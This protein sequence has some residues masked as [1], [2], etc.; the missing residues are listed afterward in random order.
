[1][2]K[3]LALSSGILLSIG[4]SFAE[5]IAWER[6]FSTNSSNVFSFNNPNSGT[7]PITGNAPDLNTAGAF[8]FDSGSSTATSP[9][10]Q[11]IAN[12]GPTAGN[13]NAGEFFEFTYS[14]DHFLQDGGGSLNFA[15][16]Y[17]DYTVEVFGGD[18][19]I[20][21]SGITFGSNTNNPSDGALD[22]DYSI[23]GNGTSSIFLNNLY[24]DGG[25]GAFYGNFS[26]SGEWTGFRIRQSHNPDDPDSHFLDGRAIS[27]ITG[28]SVVAPVPES[29][30]ALLSLLA[31][32]LLIRRK[33]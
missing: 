32:A 24:A 5:E 16:Q 28:A 25:G 31:S 18:A 13:L 30:S 6:S 14:T 11:V 9:S 2:N 1:M 23:S 12:E 27:G 26:I 3:N 21:T 10:T 20:D 22:V 4:T 7:R 8:G 17:S 15:W 29:S 33:R 19:V